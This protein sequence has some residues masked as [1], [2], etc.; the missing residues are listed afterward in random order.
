MRVSA[1]FF[2]ILTRRGLG[3]PHSIHRE[4]TH[5]GLGMAM[6]T[7]VN[8]KLGMS[9]LLEKDRNNL[10]GSSRTVVFK[11]KCSRQSNGEWK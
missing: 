3:R 11:M 10:L 8:Q 4:L 5:D 9:Q 2:L 7:L 1:F 6:F